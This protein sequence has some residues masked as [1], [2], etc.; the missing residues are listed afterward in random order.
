MTTYEP[1]SLGPHDVEIDVAAAGLNFRDVMVTLGVVAVTLLRTLGAGP[2]RWGW[3]PAGLCAASALL[4]VPAAPVK[5]WAFTQG[6]CIAKSRRG[7][8]ISGVPQTLVPHH[9]GGRVCP[10]GLRHRLLFAGASRA[11]LRKGQRVLIHSAMGGVGQAAIALAKHVGAEIYATAGSESKRQQLRAL[12]VRAAFDSH[13]FD[14]YDELLAATG[15]EGVDVVLNSLAGRHIA[16]CLDALRPG[17]WHCEIGKVDIYADNALSLCVFRK[18][19]RF[20]AI[21]VDRLMNDDPELARELSQQCMNLLDQGAVPSLP[22]TSF[23]YR[24]YAEALR[25]MTTGQ[26][27][28]KLVLKAPPATGADRF[29]IGDRRPFLDPDATYLI[30]GGLGGFGRLLL[31]YLA[32]AGGAPSHLAGP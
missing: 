22:T 20:A 3:R 2:A 29:P 16:L 32:A 1:V 15:G 31:P 21:D 17:G 24:D 6:G 13:A 9:G 5:P 19:L 8:R 18:N 11:R 23:A 25:L 30:T 10:V 26:H 14:W 28:G 7:Q 27:T 12:G 4:C